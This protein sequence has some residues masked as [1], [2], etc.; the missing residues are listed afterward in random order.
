MSSTK[1]RPWLWIVLGLACVVALVV[2]GGELGLIENPSTILVQIIASGG[3]VLAGAMPLLKR[4]ERSA[5]NAAVQASNAA[6]DAGI[7]KEQTTNS[8]KTN[9]REELDERHEEVV[10]LF[11]RAIGDLAHITETQKHHG[12]R[13]DRIQSDQRGIRRDVGRNMDMT[14]KLGDKLDEHS[15]KL[16]ELDIFAATLP[17]AAILR[18]LSEHAGEQSDG[19]TNDQR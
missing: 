2:V 16:H 18:L 8:H 9:L 7:A 12:D 10:Q 4:A 13:M 3:L 11:K 14:V 6:A 19:N 15:E 5:N 1:P 17:R